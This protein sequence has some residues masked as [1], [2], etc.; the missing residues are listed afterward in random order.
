M[1]IQFDWNEFWEFVSNVFFFLVL[2]PLGF[3]ML[4]HTHTHKQFHR[5]NSYNPQWRTPLGKRETNIFI[6]LDC[7]LMHR[8]QAW[9]RTVSFLACLHLF[10][11]VSN[12]LSH[13]LKDIIRKSLSEKSDRKVC[14]MRLNSAKELQLFDTNV[15]FYCQ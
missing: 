9:D 5:Y 14:Y 12:F 13:I 10:F 11:V 8:S 2:S 7:V 4:L 15:L 1:F 3:N 6:K